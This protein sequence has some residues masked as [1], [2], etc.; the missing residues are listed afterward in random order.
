VFLYVFFFLGNIGCFWDPAN[1]CHLKKLSCDGYTDTDAPSCNSAQNGV[2]TRL[3]LL[4]NVISNSWC[5]FYLYVFI[6]NI[7]LWYFWIECFWESEV[8]YIKAET[9]VEYNDP[10]RCNSEYNRSPKGWI[11]LLEFSVIYYF[12]EWYFFFIFC[13]GCFWEANKCNEKEKEC[14]GHNGNETLCNSENNKI[15]GG[16]I[17]FICII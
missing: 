9:C 13:V 2:Y 8:C 17:S 7:C 4:S 10:T 6:L 5:L 1:G 3:I 15:P 14:S 11:F 12:N 16:F